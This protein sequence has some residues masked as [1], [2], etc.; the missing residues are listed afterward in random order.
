MQTTY[1]CFFFFF[2]FFFFFLSFFSLS[3]IKKREKKSVSPSFSPNVSSHLSSSHFYKCIGSESILQHSTYPRIIS[4]HD[5]EKYDDDHQDRHHDHN[6][7]PRHH[8]PSRHLNSYVL[9]HL[10]GLSDPILLRHPLSET[11]RE[12]EL[13]ALHVK[14]AKGAL[15]RH[16]PCLWTSARLIWQSVYMQP[17]VLRGLETEACLPAS[18]TV[19]LYC[20]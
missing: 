10:R 4:H 12:E 18:G 13:F 8:H 15:W 2:F 6:H 5:H 11:G 17:R 14:P 9:G 3:L 1:N 20:C 7:H 19:T 16:T